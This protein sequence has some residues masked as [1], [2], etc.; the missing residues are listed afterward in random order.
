MPMHVEAIVISTLQVG[1]TIDSYVE[2][3]KLET[4][5]M[6]RY[7]FGY[8]TEFIIQDFPSLKKITLHDSNFYPTTVVRF[9]SS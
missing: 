8:A 2:C 7:C 5:S 4:L 6:N 1:N 9:E 3:F